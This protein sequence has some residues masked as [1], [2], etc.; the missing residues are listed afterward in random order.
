MKT[1]GKTHKPADKS[2]HQREAEALARSAAE[3]IFADPEPVEEK[4]VAQVGEPT[5]EQRMADIDRRSRERAVEEKRALAQH[6]VN[7]ARSKFRRAVS[8]T[9]DDAVKQA[10]EELQR[11]ER[12]TGETA[13]TGQRIQSSGADDA[14]PA[15]RERRSPEALRSDAEKLVEYLRQNGPSRSGDVMRATGVTIKLPLNLRT[16]VEKYL[17]GAKVKVEG[18]R[19]L[20]VYSV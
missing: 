11:L 12:M 3:R 10:Y 6:Y 19:A 4:P 7:E 8:N 2:Q 20:T 16:F 9:T 1:N 15:R 13:P 5:L 17:P 14:A 18:Q